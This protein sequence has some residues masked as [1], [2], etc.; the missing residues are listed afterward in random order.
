MPH[1]SSEKARG[2][3]ILFVRSPVLSLSLSLTLS[4]S[5]S[6]SLFCECVC[7]S[8][9]LCLRFLSQERTEGEG[10]QRQG[11]ETGIPKRE[12]RR[13]ALVLL[14]CLASRFFVLFVLPCLCVFDWLLLPLSLLLCLSVLSPPIP[15]F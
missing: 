12:S 10:R 14:L 9:C 3:A 7:L 11:K 4:L 2:L 15:P 6:L 8:L 1:F 5:L 13:L